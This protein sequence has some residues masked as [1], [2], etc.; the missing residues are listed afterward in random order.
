MLYRL[1]NKKQGVEF[2]NLQK[3][4]DL[5]VGDND[6]LKKKALQCIGILE[7]EKSL[8]LGD[9]LHIIKNLSKNKESKLEHKIL[10]DFY[11]NY[12]VENEIVADVY[13]NYVD[14]CELNEV[15]PLKKIMFG[16]AVRELF[17][18]ESTTVYSAQHNKAIRIYV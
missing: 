2:M 10:W 15:V 3:R 4:I 8:E 7:L 18:L 6:E 11:N 13:N 16:K 12:K 9:F 5:A 14:F 17:L 1:Q